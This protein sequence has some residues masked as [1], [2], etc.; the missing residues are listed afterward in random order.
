MRLAGWRLS[1]DVRADPNAEAARAFLGGRPNWASH[2]LQD[3]I[4]RFPERADLRW[5]LAQISGP[6]ASYREGET[7]RVS[8]LLVLAHLSI[9]WLILGCGWIGFFGSMVKLSCMT[10]LWDCNRALEGSD[11]VFLL[12]LLCGLTIAG[13]FLVDRLF[14]RI[15]FAYLRRLPE[16]VCLAVDAEFPISRFHSPFATPTFFRARQVFFANRYGGRFE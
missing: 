15:W 14:C 4:E 3:A 11:L 8:D 2:I 10:S 13:L 5:H 7:I 9:A 1:I 12:L 16:V 6:Q